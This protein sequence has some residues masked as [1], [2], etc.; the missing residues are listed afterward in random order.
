MWRQSAPV[1]FCSA[2]WSPGEKSCNIKEPTP[3]SHVYRYVTSWTLE[4]IYVGWL[5]HSS[6]IET[7]SLYVVSV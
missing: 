7:N 1:Y 5:G 2:R 4:L 6:F 3:C